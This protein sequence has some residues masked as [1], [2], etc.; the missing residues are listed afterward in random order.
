VVAAN[1]PYARGRENAAKL[2]DGI[3]P[4]L[5]MGGGFAITECAWHKSQRDI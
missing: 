4:P 3:N 1:N 2:D 5:Q